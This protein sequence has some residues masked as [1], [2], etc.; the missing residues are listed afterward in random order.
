MG[1]TDGVFVLPVVSRST[2]LSNFWMLKGKLLCLGHRA[3]LDRTALLKGVEFRVLKVQHR[4]QM[5]RAVSAE[6]LQDGANP[7]PLG[8]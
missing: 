4:K 1:H 5:S 6:M 8:V 2:S 7:L 3:S